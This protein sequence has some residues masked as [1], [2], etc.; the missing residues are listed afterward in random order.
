MTTLEVDTARA[1]AFAGRM[2][3]L[4]NESFVGLMISIGHQTGL[5]DALATLPPAT[6]ARIA[7]TT[8]LQERYVREWLAALVVGGIIDYDAGARSYHL[9]PEHAAA[10]TRAAGPDNLAFYT[11]YLALAGAVEQPLIDCFRNGG[12]VPY[13]AFARFQEL[14]REE[15]SP[16]YDATLV[17]STLPLVPGLVARLEDG[18]DVA[19]FGCGGGHA[20]TVMARAF[21]K[22]RF[23]GYDFSEDG[24]AA[25]RAEAASLGLTNVSFEV[26]DIATLET[27]GRF[28]LITAFDTVHDQARPA[29]VLATVARALRPGGV[30]LL[31]DIAGSSNLEENLEH[32]FAPF[33]YAVSVLHCMTVSLAQGGEGLGTM[34]GEQT[35]RRMLGEAGFTDIAVEHV[36]GDMINAYYICKR[37]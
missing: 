11:Q 15:T 19:D 1:E 14:Q 9:P 27:T 23:T 28:D 36:E 12:G 32:P 35:A 20:L 4:L 33:L 8:G 31:V 24:I 7:Q 30:F 37:S 5:F 22:S 2:V 16:I 6:S 10:L 21:P 17:Q 13:S 26:Q 29:R 18:V 3:G 34:W 25:G